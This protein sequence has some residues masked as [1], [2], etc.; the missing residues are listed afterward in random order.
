MTYSMTPA[1]NAGLAAF[2]HAATQLSP[3]AYQ[4]QGYPYSRSVFN[5]TVD[6]LTQ[7]IAGQITLDQAFDRIAQDVA[8]AL[9]TAN[10]K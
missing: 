7:V 1:G 5:P 8:D 9:A 3:V 2:V 4:L 6:R 10:K